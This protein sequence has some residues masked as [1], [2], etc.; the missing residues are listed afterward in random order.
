MIS[1]RSSSSRGFGRQ[2]TFERGVFVFSTITN[3][4]IEMT[5]LILGSFSY[6]GM[7]WDAST[8]QHDTQK[9]K[10]LRHA[11]VRNSAIPPRLR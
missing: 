4:S 9:S 10:V 11:F 3:N 8:V 6:E 7:R 2:S 1:N 5:N